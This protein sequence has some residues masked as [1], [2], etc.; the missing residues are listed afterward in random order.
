M[1][2]LVP[3]DDH[4]CEIVLVMGLTAVILDGLP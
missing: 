1:G 3:L 2:L 4:G